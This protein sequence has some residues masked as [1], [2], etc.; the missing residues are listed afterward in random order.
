MSRLSPVY[1][2]L[3]FETGEQALDFLKNNNMEGIPVKVGMELYYREGPAIINRL[4]EQNHSIFLDLK[5]HDIPE[6]VKRSMRNLARMQVEVV[7]VHAQGGHKMMKAAKEGLEEGTVGDDRPILLAVTM[8]TSTDQSMLNEELLLDSTVAEAVGH[9]ASL[10]EGS[11]VDG[12][13]C[14]VQEAEWIKKN[15]GLFALTPGIRLQ[16]GNTHDQKR[17]ATPG[18]ALQKGS[19]SIVVGRAIREAE[20][21]LTT[22]QEIKEEFIRDVHNHS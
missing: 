13:V 16:G 2:A 7:N 1:F 12:V 14:S 15:T 22:Y 8:L 17:I 10:A 4:K 5:L 3:D 21:P 18:E 20:D 6:T 19:D 11:G 9:Y